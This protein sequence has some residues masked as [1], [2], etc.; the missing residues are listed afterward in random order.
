MKRNMTEWIENTINN[1]VKIPM[2]ILSFPAVQL[3][4]ISVYDLVCNSELQA[5]GMKAI[6]NRFPTAAAISNMDLSVEAEAFG[7]EIHFSNEEV[8]TVIG[9]LVDTAEDADALKIPEVGSA[10]TQ[11]TLNA[12]KKAEKL[13]EDRPIFAGTIGPFSL[14]GRL[15]QVTEIMLKCILEP[16]L[17]HFVTQ[18][19]TTFL[20]EY[21]KAFKNIGANGVVMAEPVAGLIS[22]D[23]CLEFSSKYIKQIID[24]VVDENFIVIYHNCGNTTKLVNSILA[25]G[26]QVIHIGNAINLSDVLDQYPQDKII[27]GNVDPA[28]QFRHGTPKSVSQVTME[29]LEQFHSYPNWVISSGCD[30]PPMSPLENIEAFFNTVSEFYNTNS[31]VQSLTASKLPSAIDPP[32]VFSL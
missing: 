12:I 25:C 11:V 20:L 8:P 19:A 15:M 30:I 17:A 22:P 9:R 6:A 14:S 24:A 5:R 2:S 28:G 18:K 16:Q 4:D 21:I 10:R 13:I 29:L 26:A 32:V 7:C 27:M 1:P 23:L 31:S 3:L